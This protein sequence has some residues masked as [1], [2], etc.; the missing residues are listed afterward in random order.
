MNKCFF[1]LTILLLVVLNSCIPQKDLIY[2][3]NKNNSD[4]KQ[5]VNQVTKT[6][7]RVQSFD[8]LV[9]SI[10]TSDTELSKVFSV[11]DASQQRLQSDIVTYFDGFTINDQG[12][13]RIPILG[14]VN[15]IGLTLEEIRIKI[16]NKLLEEYFK[17]ESNLYVSVKMGGLRYTVNGE[18]SKPGTNTIY[19]QRVNIMEAIANSGDITTVGN[20]KNVRLIRQFPH[21][22]ETYSLDLTDI[23]IMQ[24]PYFYLQSNDYI[25]IEPLRQKSWGTGTTGIQTITTLL[26]VFTLITT[27]YLIFNR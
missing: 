18:I 26:S 16:E 13:V 20:R 5:P 14:E 9:I 8:I 24:S 17:K 10:K 15:V 1:A 12:N 19:Q 3:Q 7:Y 21:G 22:T 6:P 27:T 25:Y 4:V 11:S 23:N 2:L